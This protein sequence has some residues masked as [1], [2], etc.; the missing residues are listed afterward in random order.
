MYFGFENIV[1]KYGKKNVIDNVTMEFP[2]GKISTIIG[3]NGC[4][5]SSML[6]ILSKAIKPESGRAL[7]EGKDIKLYN[8]KILAKKLAILPQIH[9]SP[10]DIDVKTLVSYGRFPYSKF[11]KKLTKEDEEIIDKMID[12][13]G[14]SHL[15]ESKVSTLSGGEKQRAW[16]AMT[17]C[18]QPEI[19]V[20][21]EPTT[22]LDISYQIEVLELI[23]SLN[24]ELKITIVMVLHDLNLTAR[25][26]D[27]LF[28]IKDGKVFCSGKVNDVFTESMMKE[29]F[30][31]DV[32]ICFD[33]DCPYFLPKSKKI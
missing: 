4:G 25:Y 27:Y 5:K 10:E 24:K 12:L 7:V 20:L 15:K 6:K 3:Q 33:D 29:I 21:D 16:I 11:L 13:T 1:I 32:K 2:K 17:L 23:K 26:S 30:N 18:Q 31:V 22:Y 28:A 14:L 19:L 8:P 9:S